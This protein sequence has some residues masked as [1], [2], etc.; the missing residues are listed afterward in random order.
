MNDLELRLLNQVADLGYLQLSTFLELVTAMSLME[1]GL[2]CEIG[3][4]EI[5]AGLSKPIVYGGHLEL[6]PE[7]ER[8]AD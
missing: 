5:E 6:T 2:I 8:E 4:Q 1:R 7:G 3:R